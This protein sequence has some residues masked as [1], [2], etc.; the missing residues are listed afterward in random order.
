[1]KRRL[2]LTGLFSAIIVGVA[3]ATP[4]AV[5]RKGCHGKPRHCHSSSEI[6]TNGRRRY[7]AGAF[8]GKRKTRKS[9]RRKR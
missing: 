3:E 6:R 1:M 4:G 2:F 8:F 7:V 9:R 5:D